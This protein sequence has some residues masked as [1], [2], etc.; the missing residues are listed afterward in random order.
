[1]L[2]G[3]LINPTHKLMTSP[4]HLTDSEVEVLHRAAIQGNETSRDQL[5]HWLMTTGKHYFLAQGV[6]KMD[7]EDLTSYAL[8]QYLRYSATIRLITHWYRRVLRTTWAQH[9]KKRERQQM[10]IS[11]D[12]LEQASKFVMLQVEADS[13]TAEQESYF[14]TLLLMV[15][16]LLEEES[17][18]TRQTVH[19]VL[20]E[21]K[22]YEEIA[23]E[24]GVNEAT[25]RKRVSRFYMRIR[26]ILKDNG[27]IWIPGRFK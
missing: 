25:L 20:N 22:S 7:A 23:S 19:K 26:S 2:L 17:E 15:S 18:L 8:E 16:H 3:Y 1:M 10:F 13:S 11:F 21:R 6:S 5:I 27:S 4:N 24:L 9:L 12:S 14:R